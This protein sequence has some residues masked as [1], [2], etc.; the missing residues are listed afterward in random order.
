MFR[1]SFAFE[2]R[3][4]GSSAAIMAVIKDCMWL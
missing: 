1:E 4:T 2:M 3:I